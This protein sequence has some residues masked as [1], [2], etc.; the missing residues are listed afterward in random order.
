[1]AQNTNNKIKQSK[2]N[3]PH[4]PTVE[5]YL[6]ITLIHTKQIGFGVGYLLFSY[7]LQYHLYLPYYISFCLIHITHIKDV[8]LWLSW[9]V[10]E[11]NS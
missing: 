5:V 6:N 2:I 8:Q 1:M 11:K 4:D 9:L 10:E 7:V 3:H